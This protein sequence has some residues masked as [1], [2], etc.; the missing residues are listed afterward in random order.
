MP[1]SLDM[2]VPSNCLALLPLLLGGR[3]SEGGPARKNTL[4]LVAV[5][6]PDAQVDEVVQI[7][8]VC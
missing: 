6:A 1:H 5:T 8:S 3:P 2:S 7:A 4:C